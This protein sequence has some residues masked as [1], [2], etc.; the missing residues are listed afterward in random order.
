MAAIPE[1][2]SLAATQMLLPAP[3]HETSAARGEDPRLWGDPGLGFNTDHHSGHR[4]LG[5]LCAL[6]GQQGTVTLTEIL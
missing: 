6:V 4:A 1:G 2:T 3:E 5:K